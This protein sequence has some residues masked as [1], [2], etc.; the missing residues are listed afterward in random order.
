[1]NG[2]LAGLAFWLLVCAGFVALDATGVTEGLALTVPLTAALVLARFLEQ[3]EV[4]RRHPRLAA[5]GAA[6]LCAAL[7]VTAGAFGIEAA[8]L[9]PRELE[10]ALLTAA[11][12]SLLLAGGTLR[13]ALLRP[14]GL[15]P[16]SP[17]HAVTAVAVVLTL[18]S[19]VLLFVQLQQEPATTIPFHLTD[20]VVS[21]V[22]DLALALAGVGTFLTRGVAATL[23][24]LDLRPLRVRQ[25]GWATAA[26]VGFHIVVSAMEWTE[27]AVLPSLHALEDRFDYEFVGIPPLVGAALVSLTAGAGEEI[28]F[29]GALQPRLG[30]L[31]T[32]A[33]F[34]AVHVQY[35]LPGVFMIFLLGVGLGLLKR[36]T[37]TTFTV[38]VHVVYDLG[39]FLV[40]L[41]G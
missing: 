29:R 26:A 32:A 20:S 11:G 16:A 25:L 24:R 17:V 9:S 7:T 22:S 10:V 37:S 15:D 38:V 6:S 40:D 27:S 2:R 31:L 12:L 3:A 30:I 39:A 33:L 34:A 23:A 4:I 8:D 18:V 14:L 19:S 1:M 36:R 28:L 41:S 5:F 13:T 35:Q 21:I